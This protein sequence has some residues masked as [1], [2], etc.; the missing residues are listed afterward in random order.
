MR[1]STP[2]RKILRPLKVWLTHF[3]IKTRVL[4][5][6]ILIRPDGGLCSQMHFYMIGH[7]FEEKGF[8]VKYTLE[9]FRTNGRDLNGQYVYNFDL[10]KAFPNIK[11][12]IASRIETFF[13]G[14]FSYHNDYFDRSK[15]YDWLNSKPPIFLKGY[16][17]TPAE[18]YLE[19]RDLFPVRLQ[20]LDEPNRLLSDEILTKENSVAVH[21]RLGDL[22]GFN[23]A[24]GEPATVSYFKEAMRYIEE[25]KGDSFY[26]FFSVDP[27]WVEEKL[28]PHLDLNGNFFI[29]D[30]NGSEK[31]YMD[32]I[33]ISEC[34]N[35]ISSKGSL[36]KYGGFLCNEM[37]N[38]ITVVDDQ[39]ERNVWEGTDSRIVFI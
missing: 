23:P 34:K 4:D 10:L 20:V 38:I 12:S 3:L 8:R 2:I 5:S 11:I 18:W 15:L 33:L 24:Y 9:W 21:V 36:G 13:Y 7:H 31:G 16:Y 14:V 28:I 26:Y 6:F 25:R 22:S 30:L 37:Q 17:N 39:Y 27:K 32:A 19:F 29:V 35:Q 1:A